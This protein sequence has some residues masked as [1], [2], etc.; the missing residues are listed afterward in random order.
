MWKCRLRNGIHFVLASM[1]LT[2]LPVQWG[3]YWSLVDLLRA[4]WYSH[5]GGDKMAEVWQTTFS[6]AF[7]YMKLIPDGPIDIYWT[8]VQVMALRRAGDKPFSESMLI[9]MSD[10]VSRLVGFIL[11]P[12]GTPSEPCA[13]PF[14]HWG[15]NKMTPIFK[16]IFLL[17][18]L[19]YCDSN[20]PE[21]VPGGPVIN[22]SA[23]V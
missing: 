8:L 23:L 5:W 19:W 16:H 22:K 10:H 2:M 6:N 21:I 7:S 1:W 3:L 4:L 13:T 12:G 9:K 11:I 18:K 14:T 17:K 15:L 20:F